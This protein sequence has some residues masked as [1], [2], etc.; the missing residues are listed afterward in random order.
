LYRNFFGK[1]E[2]ILALDEYMEILD[3][4]EMHPGIF[5]YGEMGFLNFMLFRAADEGRIRLGKAPDAT[6]CS[7]F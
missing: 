5:K 3:F 4:T 1:K 7:R 6:D 2:H